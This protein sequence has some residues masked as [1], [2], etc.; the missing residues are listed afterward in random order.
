MYAG[1]LV[2]SQLMDFLPM[3]E[4]RKCVHRYEGNRRIRNLAKQHRVCK[5]GPACRFECHVGGVFPQ[6]VIGL[7]VSCISSAPVL[8]MTGVSRSDKPV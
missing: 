8:V 1:Q 6:R 5:F 3:Y 2:F 4:C 7:G